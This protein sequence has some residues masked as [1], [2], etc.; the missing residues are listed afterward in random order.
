MGPEA[1]SPT[2]RASDRAEQVGTPNPFN[3]VPTILFAL[4][5]AAEVELTVY[6]LAG[7]VVVPDAA[8]R[9]G[10]VATG[11]RPAIGSPAGRQHAP[12]AAR[13]RAAG[14]RS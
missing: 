1:V 14:V 5:E 6:S 3:P 4:P 11:F 8:C 10:F 13:R 9:R 12:S 2:S 7:Q